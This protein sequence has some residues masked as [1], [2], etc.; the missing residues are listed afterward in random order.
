[1]LK[2]QAPSP[3]TQAADRT[4]AGANPGRPANSSP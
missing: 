3:N 4:A 2:C 1:M